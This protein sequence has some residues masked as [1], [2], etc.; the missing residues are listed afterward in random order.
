MKLQNYSWVLI[1]VILC[2][3]L[4]IHKE[5][6]IKKNLVG[7]W[8][9]TAT[10]WQSL[11]FRSPLHVLLLFW[12]HFNAVFIPRQ[13][14]RAAQT[15]YRMRCKNLKSE[16]V[17]MGIYTE[18]ILLSQDKNPKYTFLWAYAAIYWMINWNDGRYERQCM[19]EVEVIEVTMSVFHRKAFLSKTVRQFRWKH[20]IKVAS[21]RWII[22]WATSSLG[23]VVACLHQVALK[24]A[25]EGL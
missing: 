9:K 5:K 2:S 25:T 12:R 23:Q 11:K 22:G 15:G 17:K 3:S 16:K 21:C 8:V 20:K 13:R 7:K 19:A 18:E 4:C 14:Q 6:A 10:I 1:W 24:S